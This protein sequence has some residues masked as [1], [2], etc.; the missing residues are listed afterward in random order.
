MRSGRVVYNSDI[1]QYGVIR[2]RLP[3]KTG[4]CPLD[5]ITLEEGNH[6]FVE[7]MDGW[8]SVP[9]DHLVQKWVDFFDT[10]YD[11]DWY[12]NTCGCEFDEHYI[13]NPHE[14]FKALRKIFQCD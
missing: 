14:V 3:D 1:M 6:N 5:P 13:E 10:I 11:A 9:K 8:K 12:V 2:K 7:G 4:V